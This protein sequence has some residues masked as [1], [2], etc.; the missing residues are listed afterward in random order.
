MNTD[1]LTLTTSEAREH[2]PKAVFFGGRGGIITPLALYLAKRNV[3]LFSGKILSDAFF[4]D[5]FFYIGDLNGVKKITLS[6]YE[7]SIEKARVFYWDVL[8]P[9]I[10]RIILKNLT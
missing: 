3:E 7:I 10:D 5:Y 8:L 2:N 1:P 4:G 9:D 6:P